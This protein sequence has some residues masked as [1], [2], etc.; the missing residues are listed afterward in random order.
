MIYMYYRDHFP[1][2]FHAQYGEYEG[3]IGLNPIRLLEG[4][5][6][7]RVLGLAIEWATMYAKELTNAW[8]AA[9]RGE[10]IPKVPP[11]A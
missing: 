7:P 4:N 2:H 11:L 5:L 1:P 10:S 8:H 6:P 9:S 3:L